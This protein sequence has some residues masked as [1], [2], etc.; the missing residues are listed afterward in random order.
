MEAQERASIELTECVAET[1]TYKRSIESSRLTCLDTG[2]GMALIFEGHPVTPAEASLEIA[3]SR[4]MKP[5]WPIRMGIH[6][7]P[8][9]RVSDI[10]GKQNFKGEGINTAQRVMDCAGGG[11][12]MLT[13]RYATILRSYEGWKS[14]T[15]DQ[16]VRTVKHGAQL[17]VW[18]LKHDYSPKQQLSEVLHR[19]L[20]PL[21]KPVRWAAIL[22]C[23][24]LYACA[25]LVIARLLSTR[26]GNDRDY[27]KKSAPLKSSY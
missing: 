15:V 19:E 16:G 8:V 21:S 25:M 14:R 2:D 4:G 23:I 17:R 12:I 5:R 27:L 20:P 6:S 1:A 18:E 10:N 13:D 11:R 9:T 24:A 3:A 22:L 26:D 7:G